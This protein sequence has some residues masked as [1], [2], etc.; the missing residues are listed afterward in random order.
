MHRTITLAAIALA[1]PLLGG[2]AS[3][4]NGTTQAVSVSSDPPGARVEVDGDPQGS[5]PLSM[6]L[7]RKHNHLITISMDGYQTEQVAVNK[8][9]SGAVAGNILAGGFIGWGIDAANGSQ[10]KLKPDTIAVVLRPGETDE[11]SLVA[12]V[13][14]IDTPTRLRQLESMRNE[15]LITDDEYQA[16]RR[17]IIEKLDD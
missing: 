2:C 3:I 12:S 11:R 15:G 13:D 1:L 9:M 16:T 17:A 14:E 10:Y 4:V 6:E 7:K 5:T 8:V